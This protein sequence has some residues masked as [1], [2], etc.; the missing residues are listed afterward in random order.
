MERE[1][2]I[3]ERIY[4]APVSRVWEAITDLKKMQ[5][6]YFP[7]LT[8]FAPEIGFETIFDVVYNGKV[9]PHIWKVTNGNLLVILENHWSALNC[10]MK[11]V[12]QE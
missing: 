10:L 9:F 6:W 3:I 12:K 8:E 5:Q 4:N 1:P 7:S 2:V 11:M